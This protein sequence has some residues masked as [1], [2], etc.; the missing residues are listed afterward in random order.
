L[1][2]QEAALI[3]YIYTLDKIGTSIHMDQL[4]A[5]VNQILTKDH[6]RNDQP[7]TVGKH[8][9]VYFLEWYSKL[10]KIK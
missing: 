3:R 10:C 7:S 2:V 5:T 4:A 8:W 1:S 6:D 9:P